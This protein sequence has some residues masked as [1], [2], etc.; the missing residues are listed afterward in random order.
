MHLDQ[1]IQAQASSG[2]EQLGQLRRAQGGDYDKHGVGAHEPGIAHVGR[3]DGEVLAQHRQIHGRSGLRQV[4]R[5]PGK[6]LGVG[7]D[8][9]ARRAGAGVR[10][11]Q[12]G[13]VEVGGQGPLRR[14]A[15]LDLRYH[16]HLGPCLQGGAETARRRARACLCR[17]P[18]R[19]PPVDPGRLAVSSEDL[20]QI[21]RH[22]PPA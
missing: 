22:L 9:Q 17:Q 5:R 1:S 20:V 16:R 13:R 2:P 7:Q 11:G 14:A 21:G 6:E 10:L 4:V 19:V 12:H 8:R 3:A 18:G 15:P